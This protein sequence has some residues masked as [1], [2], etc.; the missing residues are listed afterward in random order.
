MFCL[1][2]VGFVIYVPTSCRQKQISIHIQQRYSL[3]E[4]DNSRI[5]HPIVEVIDEEGYS[6][7]WWSVDFD[8]ESGSELFLLRFCFHVFPTKLKF[9]LSEIGYFFGLYKTDLIL[10]LF[11]HPIRDEF[12]TKTKQEYSFV[13]VLSTVRN[14]L[15]ALCGKG[16]PKNSSTGGHALHVLC[17]NH[18]SVKYWLLYSILG[19]TKSVYSPGIL[20]VPVQVLVHTG[21]SARTNQD[22]LSMLLS[23]CSTICQYVEGEDISTVTWALTSKEWN[24]I[25][26]GSLLSALIWLRSLLGAR[27]DSQAWS[28]TFRRWSYV[29][30][31]HLSSRSTIKT[32]YSGVVMENT[33]YTNHSCDV[34]TWYQWCV[35]CELC[36]LMSCQ[37]FWWLAQLHQ[38][39]QDISEI[40]TP[41]AGWTIACD[42]LR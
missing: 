35:M 42:S 28:S 9:S 38:F 26:I 36:T 6:N 15:K 27:L 13:S 23:Y 19:Y 18:I 17:V 11:C 31:H 3:C 4:D 7:G 39:L 22:A 21:R 20:L 5:E 40:E 33:S 34:H 32:I 41:T 24:L 2:F 25:G 1:C 16:S 8:T 12:L 10:L 30:N 14:G 29:H 37:R